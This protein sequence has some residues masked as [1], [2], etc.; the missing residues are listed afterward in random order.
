MGEFLSHFNEYIDL[1]AGLGIFSSLAQAVK[2]RI[3]ELSLTTAVFHCL[4]DQVGIIPHQSNIHPL[5]Q[6]A[7]KI[8]PRSRV[9]RQCPGTGSARSEL[10]F[11]IEINKAN[12]VFGKLSISKKLKI[13]KISVNFNELFN[14]FVGGDTRV[15]IFFFFLQIETFL[16]TIS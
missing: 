6:L 15:W 10:V 12:L 7:I 8:T 14:T 9:R 4:V 16:S 1:R 13:L 5:C 11:Q 2:T 3:N